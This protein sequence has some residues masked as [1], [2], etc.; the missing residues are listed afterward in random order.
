MWGVV[1]E[2]LLPDL[3]R[4][5]KELNE[6][7]VFWEEMISKGSTYKRYFQTVE[8]GKAILDVCTRKRDPPPLNIFLEM[9]PNCDL[10]GTSAGQ[11]MTA[12][13]RKR[14]EMMRQELQEEAEESE[15]ERKILE[16]KKETQ[17][18]LLENRQHR[19]ESEQREFASTGQEHGPRIEADRNDFGHPQLVPH[20][21]SPRRKSEAA[22][23]PGEGRLSKIFEFFS[24]KGARN[25]P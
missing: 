5:E 23:T 17:A 2:K 13:L 24:K 7:D 1:H 20:A 18:A 25:D 11:R 6:S 19:V 16:A 14:E 9:G 21:P 22:D 12:E 4:R 8:S 15:K 10:E 3:E